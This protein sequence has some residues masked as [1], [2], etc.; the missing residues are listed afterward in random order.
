MNPR[1][2]EIQ[3]EIDE[4]WA[5]IR[6]FKIIINKKKETI[7]GLEAEKMT[8]MYTPRIDIFKYFRKWKTIKKIRNRKGAE[9]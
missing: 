5:L 3:K 9:A 6:A 2:E 1:L 7:A 8:I 4:H